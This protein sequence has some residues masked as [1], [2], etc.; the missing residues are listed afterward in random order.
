MAKVKKKTAL[1]VS[2]NAWAG[3]RREGVSLAAA[4][5]MFTVR[6]EEALLAVIRPGKARHG[7]RPRM[8]KIE[9]AQLA[10]QDLYPAGPPEHFNLAQLTRE[11]NAWLKDHPEH[12]A[13][14]ASKL[15]WGVPSISRETVLRALE[16]IRR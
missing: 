5:G 9:I 14:V 6:G 4:A 13:A 2:K 1:R 16:T 10:I 11:V 3:A 15:S 8:G 12:H 7:L